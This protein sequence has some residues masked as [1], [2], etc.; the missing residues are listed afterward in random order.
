VLAIAHE[1]SS[2]PLPALT[3]REREVLELL[4][5]PQSVEE[6]AQVLSVSPNTVKTHQRGVYHKLGASGRRD[7]V[8]RARRAGLLA[9]S[10]SRTAFP[11][12]T[13]AE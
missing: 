9:H 1:R 8:S 3:R 13:R 2:G 11:D 4:P 6:I 12:F 10:G 5:T 7:A